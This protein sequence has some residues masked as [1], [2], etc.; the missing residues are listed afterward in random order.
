MKIRK[1]KIAAREWVARQ[2]NF[3]LFERLWVP[4]ITEIYLAGSKE[5]IRLSIEA[6][7]EIDPCCIHGVPHESRGAEAALIRYRDALRAL[8]AELVDV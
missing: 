5:G 8:Q 3:V 2:K 7:K 4:Y 1:L 6:F